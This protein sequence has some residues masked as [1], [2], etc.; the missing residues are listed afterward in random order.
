MSPRTRK[1]VTRRFNVVGIEKFKSM[2]SRST[3]TS[4]RRDKLRHPNGPITFSSIRADWPALQ[5]CEA[6]PRFSKRLSTLQ[7]HRACVLDRPE[8]QPYS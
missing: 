6:L 8:T 1:Q 3:F 7:Q 5:P 4:C 2:A